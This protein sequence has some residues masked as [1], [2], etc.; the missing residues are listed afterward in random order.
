[1]DRGAQEERAVDPRQ[2][3]EDV[4]ELRVARRS[5]HHRDLSEGIGFAPRLELVGKHAGISRDSPDA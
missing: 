2:H 1:M 5:R 3:A 4:G